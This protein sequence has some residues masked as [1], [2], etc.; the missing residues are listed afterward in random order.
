LDTN[1]TGRVI[2]IS[3]WIT[4]K[5]CLIFDNYFI[6]KK[7]QNSSLNP[8]K[9][10]AGFNSAKALTYDTLKSRSIKSCIPKKILSS[11]RLTA[12]PDV[13]RHKNPTPNP[14]P[15]QKLILFFPPLR[16]DLGGCDEGANMY[17]IRGKNRC[18]NN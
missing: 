16:G 8:K 14:L 13:M 11:P 10:K 17:L 5:I 2:N 9:I 4:P 6:N 15:Y 12:L 3:G 1:P 7:E 18:Q